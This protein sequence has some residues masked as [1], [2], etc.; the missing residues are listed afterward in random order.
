MPVGLFDD[1]SGL[2]LGEEIF[3]D[4]R[5]DWLPACPNANQHSEAEMQAQL[6]EYLE[7]NPT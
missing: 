6:K 3:V 7:A 1:Q 2:T 5:P 4:H